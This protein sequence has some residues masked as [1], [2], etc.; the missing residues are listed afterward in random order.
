MKTASLLVHL[1]LYNGELTISSPEEYNSF[2][3]SNEDLSDPPPSLTQMVL[4]GGN[5]EIVQNKNYDHNTVTTVSFP[6][7]TKDGVPLSVELNNVE[8][9]SEDLTAYTIDLTGENGQK[10]NTIDYAINGRIEETGSSDTG[11]LTILFNMVNLQ[12]SYLEG[13]FKTYPFENIQ[14]TFDLRLPQNDFPNNIRFTDPKIDF[15]VLNSAGLPF[16]LNIK[17]ISVIEETKNS[18]LITGSYQEETPTLAGAPNPREVIESTY[19]ISNANTY[20]LIEFISDIPESVFFDGLITANP[21][22]GSQI[23]NFVTD[24]S[25]VEIG[26]ELILP[27]TGYVNNYA[28]TDT[29]RNVD[30]DFSDGGITFEN[31]NLRIISENAFPLNIAIQLYFIDSTEAQGDI[32]LDSLFDSMDRSLIC[33]SANVDG[34]GV[35]VDPTTLLSDIEVDR[36]K[37]EKIKS[38]SKIKIVGRLLSPGADGTSPKN[39]KIIAENYLNV[40][41]GVSAKTTVDPSKL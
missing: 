31:L 13:D 8:A 22:G 20:N 27:F 33:P 28:I 15:H 24:S 3:I 4:K 30:L 5:L 37:Y 36:V 26:A 7:F 6:T 34:Q 12:F 14:Q 10:T 41:L 9:F 39:I 25:R 32:V 38:T 17:E 21:E 2:I 19:E 35:T 29:I 1:L 18:K 11:T 23:S 40:S 16:S